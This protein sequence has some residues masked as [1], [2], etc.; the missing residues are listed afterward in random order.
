VALVQGHPET[1]LRDNA[2]VMLILVFTVARGV[3]LVTGR[4]G[5]VG[6]IDAGIERVDLRVWMGLLLAWT[7]FRNMPW[8]WFLGPAS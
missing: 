4:R 2:F 7:I 5:I 1:A 3:L 8:F 6:S